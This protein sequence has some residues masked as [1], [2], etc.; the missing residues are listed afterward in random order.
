MEAQFQ[1]AD[2][3]LKNAE[4]LQVR[5]VSSEIQVLEAQAQRSIA[6]A[7]VDAA[8]A[9]VGITQLQLDQTKLFAP[10]DGMISRPSVREGTYL[11]LEALAQN[12]LAVIT[13]LGPIQVVGEV[14]FDAYA[15]RRE[16]FDV[17]KTEGETLEYIL[18][19][20]NGEKYSHIGRLVAGTGEI[21]PQT[22][23]MAIAVEFENPEFLLRPS[24]T[25]ILQSSVRR[26]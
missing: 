7:N 2:V 24:L 10:I 14:P 20:P 21:D 18:V 6:A 22:Q 25:V 11:T 19:L 26:G 13:Q 4:A 23:A 17:R 1:L 12:R 5:N 3:K 15:E 8:R 16:L 9:N